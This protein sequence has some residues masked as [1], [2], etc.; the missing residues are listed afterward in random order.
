M[1]LS[2]TSE[3]SVGDGAVDMPDDG[4]P[5]GADIGGGRDRLEVGCD[6][7]DGWIREDAAALAG[8]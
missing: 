6:P 1:G 2:G 5:G 4:P 8:K 7:L 3:V